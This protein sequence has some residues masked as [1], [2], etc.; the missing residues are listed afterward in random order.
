M[1]PTLN[2]GLIGLGYIGK[3]HATAYRNIPLCFS[4]PAALARL[5]AVLRSR[6]DTEATFMD[7]AA[8]EIRTTDP[9]AFYAQPL[10]LVDICTPNALHHDQALAALEREL[11]VYCE[12]PLALNLEQ[13]RTMAEAAQQAGVLTHVAFVLRYLPAIRQ[14]KVLLENGAIGEVLN[15]RGHMFHS[16][17]LDPQRPMSWRL[18]SAESGGGVFADL[19]A[20]LLDLTRYLLGDIRRVRAETRTHIQERP[21][22]HGG[23]E[24]VDVDDWAFCEMELA[25]GAIGHIEVTRMAAGASE[26]TAFEI[27]GRKGS[28]LFHIRQPYSIRH[29]NLKSGRWSEGP[30]S[31]ADPEGERP[32]TAI[33]PSP[34]MS[35]G[36]MSD[37]HLASAYDFLQCILEG[38]PSSLD[39]QAGLAVQEVLEAGYRSAAARGVPIELPL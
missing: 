16:G 19:G 27:Y 28:I 37:L 36:L 17:Y 33:W 18:R 29:F 9:E 32:L 38:K 22:P 7:E 14:A 10:D 1:A 15:F 2:V 13:A 12:K 6:L 30:L 24:Q 21:S 11:P 20:H 8:I 25:T 23:I 3:V 31:N 5:S 39:F 4:R 35:Q 26:E 34:K